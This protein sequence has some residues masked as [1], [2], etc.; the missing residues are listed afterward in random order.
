MEDRPPYVVN[1]SSSPDKIRRAVENLKKMA[2]LGKKAEEA[3]AALERHGCYDHVVT[4]IEG[5]DSN[6]PCVRRGRFPSYRTPLLSDIPDLNGLSL[7]LGGKN[8]AAQYG[9][10]PCIEYNISLRGESLVW[11]KAGPV[12]APIEG[13]PYIGALRIGKRAVSYVSAGASTITEKKATLEATLARIQS[14]DAIEPLACTVARWVVRVDDRFSHNFRLN[15]HGKDLLE[16]LPG[17]LTSGG[18]CVRML[19]DIVKAA[20]VESIMDI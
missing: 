8:S 15:Q 6:S 17:W 1:D 18:H 13:D 7:H 9:G 14:C 3:L 10:H 20:W 19:E 12:Q 5:A 11:R 2:K 4:W 16:R